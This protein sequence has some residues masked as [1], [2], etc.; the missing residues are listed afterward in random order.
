MIYEKTAYIQNKIFTPVL[1]NVTRPLVTMVVTF[2]MSTLLPLTSYRIK[3]MA[4]LYFLGISSSFKTIIITKTTHKP[5]LP[6]IKPVL[7]RPLLFAIFSPAWLFTDCWQTR[8][9][10]AS[11]FT[12][13]CTVQRGEK[14]GMLANG[15]A[16]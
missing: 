16:D 12:C 11:L 5:Q 14:H 6:Y 7:M 13:K 3:I 4:C 9:H 1:K 2:F 10:S 8:G 15:N